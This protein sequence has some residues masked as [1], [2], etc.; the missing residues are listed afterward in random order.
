MP[1][2]LVLLLVGVFVYVY[3]KRTRTSLTRN[4]RWRRVGPGAWR[5]AF[6]GAEDTGEASPLRCLNTR[7]K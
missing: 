5:C 4:C 6:C 3:W 2:L 7:T 1:I